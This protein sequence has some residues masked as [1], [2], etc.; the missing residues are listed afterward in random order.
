VQHHR[1]FGLA[2]DPFRN[3][4]Q[5]G[6]YLDTREHADAL[7][8]IERGT[9]QAKGFT[10]LLGETGSEKTM[11]VRKLFDMLEEEVFEASML[12]VLSEAAD[13]NWTLRVA[14]PNS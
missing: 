2:D 5:Q 8:R 9:R 12:I 10:L 11:L 3:E 6:T 4:P 14:M 1:H 7:I 13:A